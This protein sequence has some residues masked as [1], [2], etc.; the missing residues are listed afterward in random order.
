MINNCDRKTK[1]DIEKAMSTK[2]PDYDQSVKTHQN[3]TQGNPQ[4]LY[5]QHL[6]HGAY[7]P[8]APMYNMQYAGPMPILP[9]HFQVQTSGNGGVPSR[10]ETVEEKRERKRQQL[11]RRKVPEDLWDY[12]LK[13]PEDWDFGDTTE[14]GLQKGISTILI[15]PYTVAP[16]W[17]EK[18]SVEKI[19]DLKMKMTAVT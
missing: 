4:I 8:T 9:D 10:E 11:I 19:V 7:Q 17:V 16:C 18:E 15:G 6:E 14:D 5:N 3:M 12:F 1:T 13:R 2:P